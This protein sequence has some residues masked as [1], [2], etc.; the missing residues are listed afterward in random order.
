MELPFSG[1]PEFCREKVLTLYELA[2]II[3]EALTVIPKSLNVIGEIARINVN[4]KSGHAYLELVEKQE[5]K[6]IAQ[7]RGIIWAERFSLIRRKFLQE[8]GVDLQAGLKILMIGR[9]NYHEVYG[10][11]F[12]VEDVDV[13]FTL[14]EM[15]LKRKETIEKLTREGLI[16]KNKQLPFPL[17]PQRLAVISSE[18]AAGLGD[19]LDRLR[20]NLYGYSFKI[21]FF[22]AFVQGEQAE[23]S[24]LFSLS[25][26]KQQPADF[27]VIIFLRGGGSE[28]DLHVFDSYRLA[29]EV[30]L[31]PLPVLV[32]IGHE[33]DQPVIN[34]VAWQSFITP[35][36][37]ADFLVQQVR[38]FDQEVDELKKEIKEGSDAL[39]RWHC[40]QLEQ[41]G[42]QLQTGTM[43]A[44]HGPVN[45]LAVTKARLGSSVRT[46]FLTQ[47]H[48]LQFQLVRLTD[49]TRLLMEREKE[50]LKHDFERLSLLDPTKVLERGYS[51]TYFQGKL[52]KQAGVL[53]PED[54]VVTRLYQGEFT[55]RVNKVEPGKDQQNE[56][57]R[58]VSHGKDYLYSGPGRITKDCGRD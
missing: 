24:L 34:Q 32:G 31:C 26:I 29:K 3:S 21:T 33:R 38:N 8:A 47:S 19:F 50:R 48:C 35:T 15:A 51:L 28:V 36:A 39:L 25:L 30:A 46:I 2:Q 11:S 56:H 54:I 57:K 9:V 6:V 12:N 20:K 10:L 4:N 41:L 37:V 1:K 58:E 44:L 55:A 42:R 49:L 17:V 45:I 13:R 43:A 52:V 22:P 16:E 40:Q 7:I 14:G 27:D 18:S 5:E 53:S 23:N